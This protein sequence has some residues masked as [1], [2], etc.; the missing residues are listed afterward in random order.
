MT[1]KER[2]LFF[3]V[4]SQWGRYHM[5]TNRLKLN[6]PLG[7]RLNPA[8]SKNDTKNEKLWPYINLSFKLDRC[9]LDKSFIFGAEQYEVVWCGDLW[10]PE[11]SLSLPSV[12]S[13]RGGLHEAE[14]ADWSWTLVQRVP[15]GKA[16]PHPCA[17][18]I[19]KTSRHD[20]KTH[21]FSLYC[22]V[23]SGYS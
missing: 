16:R 11:R 21:Y 17:P 12:F 22:F 4:C 18:H 15:A 23:R 5:R 1:V 2:S 14:Q 3:Q 10:Q 7:P 9:C 19:R 8:T 20:R 6:S 13:H